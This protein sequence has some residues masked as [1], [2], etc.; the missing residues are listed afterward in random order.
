MIK[1]HAFIV[2]P[3]AVGVACSAVRDA[4]G[5]WLNVE[6][7]GLGECAEELVRDLVT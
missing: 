6:V 4:C 1:N 3:V 5:D 7:D 2:Q